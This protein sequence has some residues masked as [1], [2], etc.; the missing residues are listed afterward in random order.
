[1]VAIRTNFAANPSGEVDAANFFT[2]PGTSGAAALSRVQNSAR[3]GLYAV[4][5]TWSTASSGGSAGMR[6]SLAIGSFTGISGDVVSARASVRSSASK[7]ISMLF[8]LRMGTV[9][10]GTKTTSI[11]TAP[12]GQWIDFEASGVVATGAYDNFEA[13]VLITNGT[14][15]NIGDTLDMDAILIERAPTAGPYF[16]GSTPADSTY[17]YSWTGAPHASTSIAEYVPYYLQAEPVIEAGKPP[18]VNLVVHSIPGEQVIRVE[19]TSSGE[20]TIV[21]GAR[22][23]RASGAAVIVDHFPALGTPTTY[24]VYVGTHAMKQ[25][26]ITVESDTGWLQDPIYPDQAVPVVGHGGVVGALKLTSESLESVTYAV[27][28]TEHKTL[29]SRY[30]VVIGSDR[31]GAENVTL[32]HSSYDRALDTATRELVEDAPVLVFRPPAGMQ[33]L[34]PVCYLH[35][36]FTDMPLTTHWGGTLARFSLTG[37]LVQAVLTAAR[38]GLATYADVHAILSG[39]TYGDV[40]A[41]QAGKSYLDVQKNPTK[42]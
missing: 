33:P 11:I 4:R 3:A 34:P 15:N 23:K 26:T 32:T 7:S 37:N 12:A 1:M 24:T 27:T 14:V 16:D 29:G 5:Q 19:R 25:T 28:G 21:P 40:A 9:V 8:R 20:T 36:T 41:L 6:H 2:A 22:R 13:Y 10:V 38:S 17:V 31:G 18:R 42:I 30:G 39:Y 35:A